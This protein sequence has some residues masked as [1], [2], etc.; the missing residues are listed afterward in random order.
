[1]IGYVAKT[2][3]LLVVDISLAKRCSSFS[4]FLWQHYVFSAK[5]YT[6]MSDSEESAKKPF[7]RAFIESSVPTDVIQAAE[8]EFDLKSA[9]SFKRKSTDSGRSSG[10]MKADEEDNGV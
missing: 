1:M 6:E 5:E 10:G 4:A 8:E 3:C 7:M 2:I 9:F